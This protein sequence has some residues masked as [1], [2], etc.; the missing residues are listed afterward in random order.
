VI[1][2][3]T[4]LVTTYITSPILHGEGDPTSTVLGVGTSQG[5]G[6]TAQLVGIP[7]S[8]VPLLVAPEIGLPSSPFGPSNI[9]IAKHVFRS[10]K[11]IG[12]SF[13]DD[14]ILEEARLVALEVRDG[15]AKA[16]V[17]VVR[18]VP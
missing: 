17:R 3:S 18:S 16:A 13:R 15:A 9:C 7:F 4:P 10:G 6:Y 2:Q 14:D 5:I 11:V 8:L 12:V 1:P